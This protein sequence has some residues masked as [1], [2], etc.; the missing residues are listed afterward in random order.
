MQFGGKIYDLDIIAP[1]Y[2]MVIIKLKS[3]LAA[4]QLTKNWT[5]EI[6]QKVNRWAQISFA[7][8]QIW[9]MLELG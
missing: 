3:K 7:E 1:L 2:E 5:V 4:I 9:S 6:Q 8:K